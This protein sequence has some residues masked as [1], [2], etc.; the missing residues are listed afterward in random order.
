NQRQQRQHPR[1]NPTPHPTRRKLLIFG[2]LGAAGLGVAA[3]I[4]N[5]PGGDT[6]PTGGEIGT[7]TGADTDTVLPTVQTP[8]LI[9][10]PLKPQ[11]WSQTLPDSVQ[12][13]TAT[14]G[15]VLA[16]GSLLT[17]IDGATGTPHWSAPRSE[18]DRS[19]IWQSGLPVV[20]DT[21]YNQTIKSELVALSAKNGTQSWSAPSPPTWYPGG[22]VGASP[23]LVVLWSASTDGVTNHR[24]LWAA[25][26]RHEGP[27]W[28]TTVPTF[29]GLPYYNQDAGLVVISCPQTSQLLAYRTDDGKAAWTAADT[30]GRQDAAFATSVTGYGKNTYWAT[31]RL[32]A[33]DENGKP[34][35]PIGVT[36]SGENGMFHAVA[37]DADTVYAAVNVVFGSDV[38]VAY[39]ASD[40]APVWRAAWPE[41]FH[42][43]SLECEMA[44]GGGNLYVVDRFSRTLVALDAAT[45]RTLW[46]Y[47]DPKP[48]AKSDGDVY[49]HVAA[50]D[51][52]AYIAY[53]S[54]VRAF[55]AK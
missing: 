10:G 45:G 13:L 47:H 41:Q 39:K 35:W 3:G 15:T 29:D 8:G 5:M 9:G 44:L 36:D 40:G 30:A 17:A 28:S 7:D 37:A 22:V 18:L 54:T 31:N 4:A 52:H 53:G 50:D 38:I 43:P 48:A 51:T 46:Q 26:P 19:D 11:Q 12:V 33:F 24:G 21:V 6:K 25:D 32:Y 16:G 2:A 1:A 27:T 20:G 14:D 34:L 55:T 23:D 49:W 42:T